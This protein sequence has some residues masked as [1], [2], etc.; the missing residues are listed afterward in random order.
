VIA[1]PDRWPRPT[2]FVVKKGIEEFSTDFSGGGNP[3][4]LVAYPD[5]GPITGDRRTIFIL[6]DIHALTASGIAWRRLTMSFKQDLGE[7]PILQTTRS[8]SEKSDVNL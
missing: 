4:Q 8:R 5:Y 7:S 2:S 6:A 3:Q 1:A